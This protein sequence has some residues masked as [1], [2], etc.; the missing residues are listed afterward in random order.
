M[1]F[2][3]KYSAALLGIATATKLC[4]KLIEGTNA[5]AAETRKTFPKILL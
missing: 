3:I 2:S 5:S 4:V 1:F